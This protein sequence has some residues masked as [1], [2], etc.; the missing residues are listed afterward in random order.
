[1]HFVAFLLAALA[2]QSLPTI[3]T[4]LTDLEIAANAAL[5][6]LREQAQATHKFVPSL[7]ELEETRGSLASGASKLKQAKKAQ[8]VLYGNIYNRVVLGAAMSAGIAGVDQFIR[9]EESH[10]GIA[11]QKPA[12]SKS[13]LDQAREDE[14]KRIKSKETTDSKTQQRKE[15]KIKRS[16]A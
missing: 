8:L 12:I 3:E 9:M 10:V 1:M 4:V 15:I 5:K 6:A 11:D 16:S 7:A 2:V 14:S 13:L